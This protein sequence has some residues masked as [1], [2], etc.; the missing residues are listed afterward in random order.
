MS[1][2]G[3]FE[4]ASTFTCASSSTC[5]CSISGG[6]GTA[7]GSWAGRQ[8]RPEAASRAPQRAQLGGE[9]TQLPAQFGDV[10]AQQLDF[11]RPPGATRRRVPAAA[12]PPSASSRNCALA[13][14]AATRR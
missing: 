10:V 13:G 1:V 14:T 5:A 2:T 9:R 4:A 8:G 7:G 6:S 12:R 3:N 11:A